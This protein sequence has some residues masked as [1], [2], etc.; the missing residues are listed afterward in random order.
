MPAQN[1]LE[2]QL[3]DNEVALSKALG[4]YDRIKNDSNRLEFEKNCYIIERFL[5][6][7]HYDIWDNKNKQITT[8]QKKRGE[9]RLSIPIV[10]NYKDLNVGE[11]TKD[12]PE[13]SAMPIGT[14]DA[15]REEARHYNM[16]LHEAW[17]DHD[18]Q[19]KLAEVVDMAYS[20]SVGHL[21]IGWDP[22]KNGGK[23]GYRAETI[24]PENL[25]VG[26]T[27][28][29]TTGAP[30]V[31]KVFAK[32]IDSIRNSDIYKPLKKEWEHKL[33]ADDD[34]TDSDDLKSASLSD[35]PSSVYD[36]QH[37]TVLC[38]EGYYK[39]YPD[40]KTEPRYRIITFS[41]KQ[42]I[43]LRNE[44]TDQEKTNIFTL[45]FDKNTGTFYGQGKVLPAIP[46]NKSYDNIASR[47]QEHINKY[48]RGV[49]LVPRGA[50]LFRQTNEAGEIWLYQAGRQPTVPQVPGT[51]PEWIRQLELLGKEIQ[52]V[53][54]VQDVMLGR[55]PQGVESA[56]SIEALVS[57]GQEAK[58]PMRR[59]RDAF[60]SK[61][62]KHFLDL[63]AKHMT[64]EHLV[65]TYDKDG[66][67]KHFYII[68]EAAAKTFLNG[69]SKISP[70]DTVIVIRKDCSVD[71]TVGSS[72]AF[73]N[74]ARQ[75]KALSM[76]QYGILSREGAA[77]F[78]EVSNIGEEIQKAN[79]DAKMAASMQHQQAPP[80]MRQF[81]NTRFTDLTPEQRDFIAQ[82]WFSIPPG[83]PNQM[84]G[85][86]QN[87]EAVEQIKTSLKQELQS[88]QHTHQMVAELQK[89]QLTNGGNN[90][91]GQ[92]PGYPGIG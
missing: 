40:G 85:T 28:S 38:A 51:P 45:R 43:L 76:L 13:W 27:Q 30:V 79:E 71:V 31:F 32:D 66:Q 36:S 14:S 44:D 1:S 80:D 62:G 75:E 19:E 12:L 92:D 18:M 72:L 70:N 33:V 34:Y 53:M 26:L 2:K 9:V 21:Q 41:V 55:I 81:L 15:D 17:K 65:S 11:L 77:K 48:T 37:G 84:P 87:T 3:K 16:F 20:K 52:D 88:N 83:E 82:N 29:D 46:L 61:I 56:R 90:V 86:I 42:R 25:L 22:D 50:Q 57:S 67:L 47:I 58:S 89:A 23:G 39:Y 10:K 91:P 78:F 24:L 49:M 60:I 4:W 35:Q 7:Y 59:A 69:K 5:R 64:K 6:G 74:E 63:A 54:N 8:P 68:G 73:T